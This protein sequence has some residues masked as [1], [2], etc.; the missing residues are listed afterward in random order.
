GRLDA[1]RELLHELIARYPDGDFRAEALFH[2]FWM[3][4][5]EGRLEAGLPALVA[6]EAEPRER[7]RA[8]Y[9]QG[10]TLLELGRP[11]EALAAYRVLLLEHAA[12]YYALLARGQVEAIDPALAA[13][14]R[15]ELP[16]FTA[17]GVDLTVLAGDPHFEAAVDL[18]RL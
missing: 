1:A 18:V 17:G 11:A 12:T 4:R 3:E 2:L 5:G 9:W 13:E 6:L 16:R 7:P 10:R 14:L 8:L 15:P